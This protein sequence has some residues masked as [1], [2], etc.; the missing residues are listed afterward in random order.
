MIVDASGDISLVK[1]R[2][3]PIK[4]ERSGKKLLASTV[5]PGD[6]SLGGEPMP[7]FK[8]R[9][10]RRSVESAILKKRKRK[11]EKGFPKSSQRV[12]I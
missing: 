3:S 7:Q 12:Q 10:Y 11:R 2:F 1:K 5:D 6:F 4:R 8:R 9:R